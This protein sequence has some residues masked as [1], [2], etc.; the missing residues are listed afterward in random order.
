MYYGVDELK[1]RTELGRPTINYRRLVY[2]TL[3]D[4]EGRTMPGE[5]PL[6]RKVE[7]NYYTNEI[8]E[9]HVTRNR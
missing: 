8:F 1:H 4:E 6:I 7:R 3:P 5:A 9:N 2:L